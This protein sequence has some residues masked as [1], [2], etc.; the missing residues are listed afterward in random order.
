MSFAS[1]AANPPPERMRVRIPPVRDRQEFVCK[2]CH[3][4]KPRVQLADTKRGLC[5]DCV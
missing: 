3:L 4:V 1:E 2:S 5:R